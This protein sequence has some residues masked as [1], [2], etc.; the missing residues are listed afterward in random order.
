MN[1]KQNN[2]TANTYCVEIESLTKSLENA[3]I[4]DGLTTDLASKYATQVAVKA[5]TKNGNIDNVKFIMEAGQFRD[6]NQVVT[7]FV[8]RQQNN[9]ILYYAL[10]RNPYITIIVETIE[11]F[12]VETIIYK[13]T[14]I[15]T[16]VI[17]ILRITYIRNWRL[18]QFSQDY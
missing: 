3:Y 17:V 11:I 5:L 6:M 18:Q 9:K 1:T 2:K 12:V 13:T 15:I 14:I 10:G 8:N 4:S 7:K 16:M